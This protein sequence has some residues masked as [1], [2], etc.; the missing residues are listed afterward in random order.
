MSVERKSFRKFMWLRDVTI[1]C[2]L[3]SNLIIYSPEVEKGGKSEN[4]A[5]C[6][7]VSGIISPRILLK[8][9]R[10]VRL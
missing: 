1:E 10:E 3:R 9:R 5:H 7:G 6:G 8:A 4:R 2:R